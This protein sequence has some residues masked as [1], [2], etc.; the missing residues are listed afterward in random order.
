MLK[1]FGLFFLST[2]GSVDHNTATP[3]GVDV[4]ELLFYLP[5]EGC[6]THRVEC[7]HHVKLVRHPVMM[8]VTQEVSHTTE[9]YSLLLL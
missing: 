9:L 1:R 5:E 2:G 6:S 4:G 7:I 8:V 3:R